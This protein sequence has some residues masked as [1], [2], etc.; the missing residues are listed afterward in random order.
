MAL[1]RSDKNSDIFNR[2]IPGM[3]LTT[4]PGNR[5]WEN[6]PMYSTVAGATEY[7]T[8]RLTEKEISSAIAEALDKGIPVNSA[9]Q[10]ITTSSAMNGIHSIDVGLLVAPV[11]RELVMLAGDTHKVDYKMS[12]GE[13]E[14]NM[15][16]SY[17]LAKEVTKDIVASMDFPGDIRS[18]SQEEEMNS[19][20]E[21]EAPKGLMA[22]RRIA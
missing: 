15:K 12:F 17:R 11:V 7:Y 8:E 21:E 16:V 14:S 1:K 6:P 3:S 10:L 18:A 22:R 4:E 9:T 5:P 20:M 2:A 19:D 13:D